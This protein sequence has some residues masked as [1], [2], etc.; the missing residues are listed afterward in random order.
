MC[1]AFTIRS[2]GGH[3]IVAPGAGSQ[4]AGCASPDGYALAACLV[5]DTNLVPS[6]G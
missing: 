3:V 4:S 1:G 6:D 5:V 2:L